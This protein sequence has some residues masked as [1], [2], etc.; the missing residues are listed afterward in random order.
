MKPII[1]V[2]LGGALGSVARF[3][4]SGWALHHSV[5]WRFPLG[6][7]IVNVVGCMVVGV[8]GGLVVKH[9]LFSSDVRLFLFTG[10]AGGFTTF[11]AF[12]LETFYL[13]RRDEVLVAAGYVASSVFLGLA[14]L[15]LGFTAVS[16][17]S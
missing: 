4:I 13:L 1:L 8:L 6:T 5:E 7:F 3:L 17:R 14:V 15:W 16:S 10:I 9:D 11:S 2:A 12:G